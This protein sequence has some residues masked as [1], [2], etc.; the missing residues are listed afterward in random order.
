MF[1][2]HRPQLFQKYNAARTHFITNP[3]LLI[4]LEKY[5]SDALHK[6]IGN[7]ISEIARDYNE[8][9]HLFPFWQN[10]PPEERGRK[11]RK[12]QYPWIEVG[13]NAIG[14]KLPRLL[15]KYGFKIRDTGLPSG[16]DGRYI[17]THQ[18][19]SRCLNGYTESAWLMIDI[20]SAGPRDNFDNVVMSPNQ[21]SGDGRWDNPQVGVKN[22]V[23]KATGLHASHLFHCTLPPVFVLSDGLI[24]PVVLVVVKPIYKMLA[25]DPS[26][27]QSG[28]P[29][30]EVKIVSI[31]NGLLLEK[32]PGYLRL[33]RGLLFPGKDDKG[34]KVE[35]VRARVSFPILQQI[36]A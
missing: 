23:M 13:E 35:K 27:N 30:E 8:A 16:P 33:H 18:A 3:Q 4:D 29:L 7:A 31:P 15:Q 2:L 20:K 19:I 9:S 22:T 25:L 5:F 26:M 28:Q 11:P 21:I 17:V 1:N 14:G 10:Y 34:K 32:A 12:D 6:I 36:D 24:T